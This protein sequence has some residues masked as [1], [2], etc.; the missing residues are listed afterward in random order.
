MKDTR[1]TQEQVA[2]MQKVID[3]WK[4]KPGPLMPILHEAQEVFGC[5]DEDVQKY[6][7]KELQLDVSQIHD[8]AT[9]Y[10]RFT[11]S[12]KGK[13]T[14]GVCMGTACYVRGSN[15]IL[16]SFK[17]YLGIEPGETT[18]DGLFTIEAVRCIGCCGLAPAICVNED[19]HGKFEAKGVPALVAEYKAQAEKA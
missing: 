18:E 5:L 6:I 3:A 12:P 10:S 1:Y 4:G 11:L 7:S 15:K 2:Q 16:E 9:F 13:Y 19:V 14:I 17:N 8:V